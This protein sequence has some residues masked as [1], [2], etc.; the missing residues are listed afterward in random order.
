MIR[1]ASL[2]TAV[3]VLHD[4]NQ[5]CRYTSHIIALADG[6]IEAAG[7]PVDVATAELIERAF[8]LRVRVIA[9]PVTGT[10]LC[11]PYRHNY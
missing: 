9:C 1:T 8:G 10:P 2:C 5:A 3:M 11:I 6:R 7:R 4:L